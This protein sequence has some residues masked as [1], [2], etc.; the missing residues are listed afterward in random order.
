MCS[1]RTC[2]CAEISR[3]L[4]KKGGGRDDDAMK[5]ADLRLLCGLKNTSRSIPSL[6][7]M[8]SVAATQRKTN[9]APLRPDVVLR[10]THQPAADVLFFCILFFDGGRGRYPQ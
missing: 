10:G 5:N 1:G 6:I 7:V 4:K 3:R 9:E 8:Q 2:Q